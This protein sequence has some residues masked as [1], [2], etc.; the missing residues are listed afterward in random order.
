MDPRS[1]YYL[2]QAIHCR[3]MADSSNAA[4]LKAHWLELAERWLQMIPDSAIPG[5]NVR[6]DDFDDKERKRA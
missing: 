4:D 3:K 2:A 5:H 6:Q 1:E